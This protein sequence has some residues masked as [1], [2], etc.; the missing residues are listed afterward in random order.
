MLKATNANFERL[1]SHRDAPREATTGLP[2]AA[3]RTVFVTI[4]RATRSSP[5]PFTR[6]WQRFCA[7]SPFAV[8]RI[9]ATAGAN[10]IP[11]IDRKQTNATPK[12]TALLVGDSDGSIIRC[13]LPNV[14][15]EPRAGVRAT[16]FSSLGHVASGVG[17]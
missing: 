13:I 11:D 7:G 16:D 15:G 14:K 17:A 8:H 9:E 1:H 12:T 4:A 5:F 6:Q 2:A 3:A 10:A